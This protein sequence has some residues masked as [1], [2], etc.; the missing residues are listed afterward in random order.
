MALGAVTRQ[1]LRTKYVKLHHNVYAP[2][3]MTLDAKDRAYAAWLWSRGEA[4]LVGNSAAAMHGTKWLSA[5]SP[6]ELARTR[7]KAPR[8]ILVHTGALAEDEIC[9]RASIDCTTPAR[10]AFDIGRR[11]RADESIV[12]IDALLNATGCTVAE[13][14]SIAT[15]YPGARG[16][17][18]LRTALELADGGAESRRRLNSGCC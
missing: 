11:I 4:T 14:E 12:H 9:M 17:R 13:V 10:T 1:T 7:N 2:K 5:D 6:A 15:R 3:G 18:G 16:I 8:G